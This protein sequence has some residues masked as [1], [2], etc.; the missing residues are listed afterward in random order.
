MTNLKSKKQKNVK[1][2]SFGTVESALTN[3]ERFLEHKQKLILYVLGAVLGIILIIIGY[4]NFI[5][6][7]HEKDA[8]TYSFK[9]Q[10]YF[11]QA[12]SL[13][14]A[15]FNLALNGDGVNMGFLEVID[16]YGSTKMGNLSKYY[17]GVCYMNLGKYEEAIEMFN[18][19][20]GNDDVIYPRSLELLGDA[21]LE[22]NNLQDALKYYLKAADKAKN[23]VMSPQCLEKAAKT[24]ILL[25]D[26]KQVFDIFTRIDKEYHSYTQSNPNIE[27]YIQFSKEKM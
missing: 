5:Q 11:E 26:Y 4:I 16:E 24:C 18:K 22:L 9:A 12:N 25:E 2:D 14:T 23:D 27:K 6:K 13:D 3:A 15:M 19:F 10:Q 21:N 17:A 20:K 7:P 8:Y 1:K